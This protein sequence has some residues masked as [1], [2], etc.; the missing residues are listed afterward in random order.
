MEQKKQLLMFTTGSDRI[1][2]GG[3]SNLKLIIAKNGPDSD[4]CQS[5]VLLCVCFYWPTVPRYSLPSARSAGA[6]SCWYKTVYILIVILL[7]RIEQII[8]PG[9]IRWLYA[10]SSGCIVC[11]CVRACVRARV[12]VCVVRACVRACSE[13][14]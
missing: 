14:E 11:V 1:P 2:V 6:G 10:C 7:S 12:C 9:K 3:L 8:L 4:R 13:S 5:I